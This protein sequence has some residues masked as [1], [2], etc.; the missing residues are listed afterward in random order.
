MSTPKGL[1][2]VPGTSPHVGTTGRYELILVRHG[3]SQW[4]RDG[5]F[6]G[7]VDIDLTAAGKEQARAA[8]RLLVREGRQ[9][10]LAFTS[11]LRRSIRSLWLM[12]EELDRVWIPVI[13]DW[14]LNERHYGA[15]TGLDKAAAA[16]V[17]GDKQI[18]EWRRSYTTRP[19]P[20][21]RAAPYDVATSRCYSQVL[22]AQLP[23]TESLQDTA[24]RVA[25][26]WNECLAPC[27]RSGRRVIV[28][29]HG[30]SLRAMLKIL[31]DI[32]DSDIMQ[33]NIPNGVP[34]L[35]RF[36]AD[37]RPISRSFLDLP[38]DAESNIL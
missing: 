29:A 16:R 11:S 7:W 4:N 30:N 28:C 17:Y 18:L 19:P 5:R 23:L 25:A 36:D 35:Y 27:I 14:R 6:T 21:A 15:L 1:D 9:F 13:T 10:D 31:D 8:G 33:L 12:L 2:A 22:P 38:H 26:F 34:I 24:G 3:E 20:L 32:S 37:M